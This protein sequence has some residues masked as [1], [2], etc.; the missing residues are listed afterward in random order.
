M[1][2]RRTLTLPQGCISFLERGRRS[3]AQ[4]SLVLIH[5]LMGTAATFAP[6]LEAL[7]E[8]QHVVALDLPGAGYSDRN[9]QVS[10]ALF[11]ISRCVHQ[12]LEAL[13]IPCPLLVGHSHGG[14]VALHL[15]ASEPG[16]ACGLVLL[17]PAHPY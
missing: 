6:L 8:T 14:T 1:Y 7:P 5:G 13:E 9:P 10:P 4:P 3:P 2:S 12:V 15:A 11:S 17:A 16:T